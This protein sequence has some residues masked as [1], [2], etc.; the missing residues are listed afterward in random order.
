[1][2][3][4]ELSRLPEYWPVE[5][6]WTEVLQQAFA[7]DFFGVLMDFVSKARNMY[8]VFPEE[9]NVFNAFR[10]CPFASTKVVILGQDPYHGVGQAH[11]LSFSVLENQKLPPS[12][13]NIF[14]ELRT[15]I[16]YE[17]KSGDLTSWA[18]QG[19]LLLNTVLTVQ[20]GKA[21]SHKDRGW[22]KFTDVVIQKL[23]QRATPVVFILW[24]NHAAKKSK[25]IADHHFIIQSPHPSPLS[26]H[27]GFFGSKPFSKANQQLKVFGQQPIEWTSTSN[28]R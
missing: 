22:E 10:L 27:R 6:D 24:G 21:H 7:E 8:E 20:S 2:N 19:V 17:C 5:S 1:M 18:L 11:G 3:S 15:D 12:L 16:G 14:K 4:A 25:Q 26:A 23:S 28:I 9:K 13:K